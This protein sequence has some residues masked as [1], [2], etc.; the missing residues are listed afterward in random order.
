[1]IVFQKDAGK[2]MVY[3]N[4]SISDIVEWDH[5]VRENISVCDVYYKMYNIQSILYNLYDTMYT[6][7]CILFNVYYT[8]H[9]YK[10]R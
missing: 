2:T 10:G 9:V 8:I 4:Y 6:I 5:Q 3:H 1:M 7:Q